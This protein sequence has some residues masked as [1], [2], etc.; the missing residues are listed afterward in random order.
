MHDNWLDVYVQ[1][2]LK[3]LKSTQFGCIK[4]ST[5]FGRTITA[6][7]KWKLHGPKINQNAAL[8]LQNICLRYDMK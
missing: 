6:H 7:Y 2:G 3:G 8:G 5:Q 4:K 1:L